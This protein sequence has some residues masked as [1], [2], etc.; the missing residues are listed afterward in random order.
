MIYGVK[1][2]L[3]DDQEWFNAV[4][5][6]SEIFNN[7]RKIHRN[8]GE[9]ITKKNIWLLD[10]KIYINGWTLDNE[11]KYI[12]H[13]KAAHATWRVGYKEKIN[14]FQKYYLF[15]YNFYD[16]YFKLVMA[17]YNEDISW[18]NIYAGN[19]V[20]YNK[21]SKIDNFILTPGDVYREISN[22]GRE[23]DTILNYII[24]NYENLPNFVA[25]TQGSLNDHE[26]VRKDWGKHMFLNMLKEAE[27][28]VFNHCY[29][30]I[31]IKHKEWSIKFDFDMAYEYDKTETLW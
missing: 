2:N 30:P 26:W 22:I 21:G 17:R 19:R 23:S 20:I 14:I 1:D 27:K 24:E 10:P 29:H 7:L 25:F 11:P 6:D 8:Y 3:F 28:R 13:C 15:N 31:I 9:Y 4:Y 18:S 5:L 12:K 16:N